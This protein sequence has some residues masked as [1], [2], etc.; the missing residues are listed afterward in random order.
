MGVAA[1]A[2]LSAIGTIVATK[3]IEL[4]LV[5]LLFNLAITSFEHVDSHGTVW[6][7]ER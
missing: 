5:S 6:K 7:V 3:S 4:A 1:P 2:I